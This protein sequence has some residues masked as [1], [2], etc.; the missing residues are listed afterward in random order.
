MNSDEWKVGTNTSGKFPIIIKAR[1]NLPEMYSNYPHLI[2]IKWKY[3]GD[4]GM[5]NKTNQ[6][7]M[8][9]FEDSFSNSLKVNNVGILAVATTGNYLKEWRYYTNDP[10]NFMSILNNS[11]EQNSPYPIDLQLFDD[12]KWESWKEVTNLE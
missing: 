11:S 12:P 6:E 4:S 10:Q 7:T 3:H 8:E 1:S 5:P 9:S 2:I